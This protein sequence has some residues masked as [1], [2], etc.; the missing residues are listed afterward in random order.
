M[1]RHELKTDAAVFDAVQARV[2]TFEIRKD[3][4]NFE[5]GDTL[6][7]RKTKYTGAEMAAGAPLEYVETNWGP[8]VCTVTYILRGPIYGLI[9]GWCIMN[10]NL[11]NG[12]GG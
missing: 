3:D 12:I 6:V 8:C 1:A 2:K 5:T 7:L 9:D 10:I 4:R 11:E